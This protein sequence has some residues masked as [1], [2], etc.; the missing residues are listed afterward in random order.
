M[1]DTTRGNP[2]AADLDHI[3]EHNSDLWENIRQARIFITGGTGF[4]G[5]WLLESFIWV[6]EKLGLNADA[7]VLTRNYEGFLQKAP[8]LATHPSVKFH[9]GD[10]RN[11]EFPDTEFS[12][13]IHAATEASTKLNE[14]N[15]LLMFDTI[16]QGTRRTLDF[17]VSCGAK[18][19]LL[20]SSGA[21]YG[22]QPPDITHIPE[23]YNGAPDVTDPT[24]AYGIG[25]RAAE[26]L[27]VLYSKQYGL[28]SKIAR[29]F[30]FV[31]PYLP[32]DAHFAIGNFIRDG[33]K[34]SPIVVKGDGTPY[35]S[36]LYSDDLAEWL[37]TILLKG[38]SGEAYNVGSDEAITIKDLAY[39]VSGCFDSNPE[40]IIKQKSEPGGAPER[41]VPNINKIRLSL[42]VQQKVSLE[43]AIRKT[44][45]FHIKRVG[46]R[47]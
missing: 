19:F 46:K 45:Y 16:V 8:H 18:K 34:G 9:I 42:E 27:C 31:G 5:C 30:A 40:V 2:L 17:A 43:E 7:V 38:N 36:Y 37:W 33:I 1:S 44:I 3:L 10:V 21:V 15:P 47:I 32:L 4:F 25:K 6:N 39:K 11:F 13:I 26:H 35:R 41:Y 24:S 29:C 22:K 20:T 28:E 12:H 14:E 23:D